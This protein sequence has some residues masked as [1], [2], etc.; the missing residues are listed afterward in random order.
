MH[1]SAPSLVFDPATLSVIG[2][3]FDDAWAL[4]AD[5]I[6]IR[7][8]EAARL[9]LAIIVL[10]LAGA[11]HREPVGLTRQAVSAMGSSRGV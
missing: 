3:A 7:G 10:E 8:R 4:I 11:G 9:E 2:T 1:T 6:E 5:T